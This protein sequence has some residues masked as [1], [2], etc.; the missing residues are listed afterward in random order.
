MAVAEWVLQQTVVAVVD[1]ETQPPEPQPTAWV[2][3][4]TVVAVVDIE[5]AGPASWQLGGTLEVTFGGPGP[6]PE[7]EP[8]TTN[9]PLL[10]LG[11][12]AVVGGAVVLARHKE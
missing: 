10:L 5:I 6:S 3:Q 1:I 4:Q 9:W 7:P 2:L 12:A 11:T 8:E